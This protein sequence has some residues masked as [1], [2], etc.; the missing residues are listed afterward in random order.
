MPRDVNT[1]TAISVAI[2]RLRI[3]TTP[4]SYLVLADY[5]LIR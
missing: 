4:F 2:E 1:E 5:E 3:S